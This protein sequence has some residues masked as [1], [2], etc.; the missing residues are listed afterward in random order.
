EGDPGGPSDLM[1]TTD[2][3]KTWQSQVRLPVSIYDIQFLDKMNG[4]ASGSKGSIYHTNNGGVNWDKQRTELEPGE[5]IT[6]PGSEGAK[7]FHIDGI[8]FVDAEHGYAAARSS[9]EDTGRVLG[10]VNGGAAWSKQRIIADSGA[11]DILFVN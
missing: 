6:L 8:S 10:T 9:E 7:M 1:A 5:T 3:G 11:R 2:G 4:W